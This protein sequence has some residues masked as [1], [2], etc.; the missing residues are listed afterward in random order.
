MHGMVRINYPESHMHGGLGSE[1]SLFDTHK[2]VC[3]LLEA[4]CQA[5]GRRDDET[6]SQ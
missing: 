6:S 1:M 5:S 2:N 3:K 4:S